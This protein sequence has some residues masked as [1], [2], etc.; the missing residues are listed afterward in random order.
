MTASTY[1]ISQFFS[2]LF[3]SCFQK[4]EDRFGRVYINKLDERG[5]PKEYKK[6]DEAGNTIQYSEVCYI[7]DKLT[8]D[9]YIDESA[10]V[11]AIKCTA[12]FSVTPLYTAGVIAWNL[13]QLCGGVARAAAEMFKAMRNGCSDVSEM[14][15]TFSLLPH[16]CKER[17]M[18]MI[19]APLFGLGMAGA[20]ALGVLKPLHGRSIEALVEKAWHKGAS[21]KDDMRKIPERKAENAWVSCWKDIHSGKEFFLAYCFQVRGNLSDRDIRVLRRAPLQSYFGI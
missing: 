20:A 17:L 5:N 19:S 9:L 7:E 18:E 8:G 16:T 2:D 12:I 1:P 11:I 21:Y 6:R 14:K 15:R 4:T 3:S 10:S 13:Y